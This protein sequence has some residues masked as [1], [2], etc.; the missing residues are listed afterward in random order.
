MSKKQKKVQH[1]P[2][3]LQ[4]SIPYE[5][6]FAEGGLIEVE[7][8]V[9]SKSYPLPEMNFKTANN[10]SQWQTAE[11]YSKLIGSFPEGT[12]VEITIYNKTIDI[13]MFQEDILLNMKNDGL[14]PYR[15][16]YNAMLLNKLSGAKKQP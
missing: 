16:E 7:P 5:R 15:E 12:T 14:D 2:Q 9:Y 13:M 8:G 4:E 10:E 3:T 6:V 1:I 11:A